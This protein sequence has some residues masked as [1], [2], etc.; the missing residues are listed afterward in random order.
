MKRIMVMLTAALLVCVSFGQ[1]KAT[2]ATLASARAKITRVI[3][4]PKEMTAVMQT[5]SPADQKTFLAEVIAAV[6]SM[7]SDEADRTE[8]FVAIVNAALAGSQKGNSLTL[9]AEVFA[10]VPP[11]AL[12]AVN[13]SLA[14]GLMNRA[15]DGNVTYT[16]SEYIKISQKVMEA[17][18]ER[19]ANEDN[20]GVRSGFAALMM[21]RGSNSEPGSESYDKIMSSVVEAMPESVQ[22]DAKNEW[23]PSALGQGGQEKTY[24]PMLA[25]V[26]GE[27][28]RPVNDDGTTGAAG[29][30]AAQQSSSQE[31]S[32]SL[33]ALRIASA[34]N[35]DTLLADIAGA[36]TD[37]SASADAANPV[38]D[39][40]QNTT[41]SELP[42]GNGEA[43]G[44]SGEVGSIVEE[45][46]GYQN[47][48][49]Q[50]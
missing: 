15:T 21:I 49:T 20:A 22:N 45:V 13:E 23:I 10:T 32:G 16:D 7:P 17:V 40:V 43:G 37:P 36:N 5:L 19:V 2:F 44:D 24:D 42:L 12:A 34:Q 18:N 8:K 30:A 29:A 25:N 3:E 27:Q 28:G 6:A 14:S 31:S 33:L 41:N 11:N 47:Q 46:I 26:D 48:T 9:V 4:N 1:A 50:E 39:A 38:V 35:L